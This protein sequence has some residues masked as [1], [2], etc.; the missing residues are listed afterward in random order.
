ML[1]AEITA[2]GL[3]AASALLLA[4]RTDGCACIAQVWAATGFGPNHRK[5]APVG[6]TQLVP[7]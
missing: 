6:C 1:R 7:W 4:D 2:A 5:L 3:L